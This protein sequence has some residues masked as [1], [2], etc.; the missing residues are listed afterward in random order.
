MCLDDDQILLLLSGKLLATSREEVEAHLDAC[1]AC[2][3][4][5]GAAASADDAPEDSARGRAPSVSIGRYLVLS[6]LG[7]G[8]MGRVYAAYDPELD[9]RVALKLLDTSRGFEDARRLMAREARALGK[10]S[11][12]N[13][14]QVYD[15]GEHEGAVF[16]A[17]ELVEGQSLDR[18][19]RSTPRPGWQELLAAF[20]DAARGISA[21][22]AQGLVHRDIKPSNIL[23]GRD[24]RVRVADFGLATGRLRAPED[25]APSAVTPPAPPTREEVLFMTGSLVGTPLYMAPEQHQRRR[26]TTASDQYSLCVA[27][28]EGLY[29]TPPFS[30]EPGALE[31]MNARLL[32]A[33][34]RGA[35]AEPPAGTEVPAWVFQALARGL[36]PGPEDRYPSLDAL[37]SA[38][39]DNPDVRRRAR[40]RNAVL[41]AAA[42][43]LVAAGVA[44][45]VASGALRNPC[46]HPEWQLSGAWDSGVETR[47]RTAF[48]GTGRSS[49]EDTAARVVALLNRYGSDW[50]KMRGEVCEERRRDP[51][52][53]ELLA[54]RDAC[55]D[56]RRNQL[57]A[58]T[59]LLAEKPSPEILDKAVPAAARLYPITYCADAEALTARVRPP[60]DPALRAS[61]AA[62][63]PRVDRIEALHS[64]GRFE[65]ALAIGEP[66]LA[67]ASALAH[68]PFRAQVQSWVGWLRFRAGDY[69]GANALLFTAAASAAEGGDDELV[70]IVSGRLLAIIGDRQRRF[71]EASVLRALGPALLARVRDKL[72]QA[73]WMNHEGI[74][75]YRMG[76]YAEAKITLERSLT[77][78]EQ[79]L[80]PDH[81]DVAM[82][83][84]NLGLTL[85]DM[86]DYPA[87]LAVQERALAVR[88][89]LLGP[90]H[91]DV[92]QSL[93]N[94]ALTLFDMGDY[95]RTLAAQQHALIIWEKTVGPNHPDVVASLSNVGMVL[96]QMGSYPQAKAASE[97]A[98]AIAESTSGPDH[99]RVAY[100][101]TNLARTL[102]RLGELDAALPRLDRA[103]AIRERLRATSPEDVAEPLLGLGELHL[104]R[105]RPAEAAPPL[106]RALA[107]DNARHRSEIQLA[108]GDALWRI[109]KDRARARTLG[110]QARMAYE[111][112]HHGPGLDRAARWLAEHPPDDVGKHD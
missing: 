7:R 14:V 76:R 100:V 27:L 3:L 101:L 12:P 89:K 98:L 9:R 70:A 36:A 77:L 23:R 58:L 20:V 57:E 47:M 88:E 45:L 64:A 87:A 73:S 83:L 75:L 68:A 21:A 66:L 22:H 44:G 33:K 56:R 48:L 26:A 1:E 104:A 94:V 102:V 108:L 65:D 61:V 105:E 90:D 11:H 25:A 86:G 29:G 18:W 5:V 91:P 93:N 97:R 107:L 110:E 106:E 63:Q 54:L 109:G 67:E 34:K 81:P 42:T 10:L 53:R 92:A 43:T 82:S 99:P 46:Q 2:R 96:H 32:A 30:I 17:M 51:Q 78:R 103:L 60:E 6:L 24:G 79:A 37:I 85:S 55:L 8:G 62:L 112:L 41:A 39:L 111:R 15:V 28:H 19:C 35:P 4:V 69:E 74:V 50:T 31:G 95:P 38:L 59:T 52:R 71:Q 72:A 49:S 16:V 13:V 84:N 80:G 40:R